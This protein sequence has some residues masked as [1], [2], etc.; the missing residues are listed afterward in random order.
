[1]H[2]DAG[3]AVSQRAPGDDRCKDCPE[4]HEPG[5]S[6]CAECAAKRRQIETDGRAQRRKRR[7]CLT[8]GAAVGKRKRD[9]KLARH[10]PRHADYYAAR[11]RA[12]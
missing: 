9:G 12:A 10:C 1:M 7:Q 2:I 3:G 11:A 8:C 6:R 5:R 4:L